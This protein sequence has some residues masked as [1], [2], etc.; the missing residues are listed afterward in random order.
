MSLLPKWQ[1]G[2]RTRLLLASAATATAVLAAAI[3]AGNAL[4]HRSLNADATRL[5]HAR[6]AAALATLQV[7]NGRLSLVEAPDQASVDVPVWVI[8]NNG[9]LLEQPRGTNAHLR[10]AVLDLAR[11][12]RQTTA[13]V[14]GPDTRIAAAPVVSAGRRGGSVVAAVSLDPYQHTERL[15]LLFSTALG[16]LLLLLGILATHLLLRRALRPVSQMTLQAREW[17]DHDPGRRFSPGTPNDELTELADTLDQLLD[18]TT[19]SLRREQRFGTE[20]AHELRTPLTRIIGRTELG[21]SHGNGAAADE[22]VLASIHENALIMQRTIDAL[23]AAARHE[24]STSQAHADVAGALESASREIGADAERRNLTVKLP[25][26]LPN[27]RVAV[28]PDLL[29]RILAPLFQNACTYA[30]TTISVAVEQERRTVTILVE[31]DGPGVPPAERGH[32]F[33]P[34]VRGSNAKPGAGAGLGLALARRLARAAGG[35]VTLAKPSPG[36][37]LAVTLP[38]A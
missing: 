29:L 13:T 26:A 15:A 4:L 3:L 10:A 38:R 21:L 5:A 6:L 18:R 34:A 32:I 30:N 24:S 28:D 20:L 36:A 7:R 33:E 27:V 23:M 14:H 11:S 16:A 22:P 17:S 9:R 1:L 12:N 2:I 35:D 19:D 37:S 8:D 31:D 25:D